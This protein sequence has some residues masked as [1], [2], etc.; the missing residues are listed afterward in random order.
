MIVFFAFLL[1]KIAYSSVVWV[2]D[3]YVV[4]TPRGDYY[5]D[6]DQNIY[7]IGESNG[8]IVEPGHTSI[9]YEVEETAETTA[10]K[11]LSYKK[12]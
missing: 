4:S 2:K 9:T 6:N 1:L 5:F 3:A 10:V 12:L 7:K 8:F 11:V